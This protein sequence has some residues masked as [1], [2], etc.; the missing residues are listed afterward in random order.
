MFELGSPLGKS[1]AIGTNLFNHLF[2]KKGFTT[3]FNHLA[4]MAQSHGFVTIGSW[5]KL[6]E[7]N[8]FRKHFISSLYMLYGLYY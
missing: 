8:S 4:P 7:N 1:K 3:K 6:L 5:R 2:N